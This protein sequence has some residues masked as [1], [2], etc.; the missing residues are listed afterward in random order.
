MHFWVK[1]AIFLSLP[2][3]FF[4]FDNCPFLGARKPIPRFYRSNK[5]V[6]AWLLLSE[7]FFQQFSNS[8]LEIF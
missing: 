5:K 2:E 7:D 1:S 4:H 6:S 3:I 8:N